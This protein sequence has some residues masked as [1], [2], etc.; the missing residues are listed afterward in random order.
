MAN[1]LRRQIREAAAAAVTGLTTT[2]ARVF[3]SSVYA[4]AVTDL[5]ALR[6]RTP[7]EASAQRTLGAPRLLERTLRL[8]VEAV[9]QATADLDDA[10]DQACKEV[11]IAL[12]MPCA[13]LA[14]LVKSVTLTDTEITLTGEG[15]QP[16]GRAAMGFDVVYMA[17]E[18]A[19]DAAQ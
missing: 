12:A 19:P 15:E 6:V 3:T 16:I 8:E 5:P 17:F 10:L 1:H 13:A 14:G 11:E 2:G 4:L 18:N 7:R 9:A